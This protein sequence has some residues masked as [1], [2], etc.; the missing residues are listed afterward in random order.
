VK[1][2]ITNRTTRN[3]LLAS[4]AAFLLVTSGVASAQAGKTYSQLKA[5]HPGWVQVPGALTSPDCVHVVPNGAKV[6]ESEGPTAG[7]VTLNGKLIAHYDSC[8]EA[9]IPTRHLTQEPG[10][11]GNGWVE[12]SQWFLSLKSGDNIDFIGGSWAVP[13]IPET[14]GALIYL[15][16]GIQPSNASWIMQ[17][18]L[19]YGDNGNFGGNYWVLASWL[20]HSNTDYYVSSPVGVNPGDVI[21]GQTYQ[22]GTSGNDLY[23][24]IYAN[25]VSNGQDSTMSVTTWGLQW[26]EAFAGVLEAY[27]VT[28]CSEYPSGRQGAVDFYKT[29][30]AHGYPKLDWLTPAKFV[31]VQDDYFGNGGPSCSF[32]VSV[33]GGS[34]TLYF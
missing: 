19:Q 23:Y 10:T 17:P 12:D 18:V 15:F 20:V 31:G 26:T 21:I 3:H 11:I 24:F 8:A 28:S 7:D 14:Y 25:D 29:T 6:D 30:V 32:S 1:N 5:E 4:M 16:N 34:S 33:S 9:S 13:S 2:A 27:N 22:T